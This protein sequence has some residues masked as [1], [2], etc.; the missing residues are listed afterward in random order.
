MEGTW[1]IIGCN[2]KKANFLSFA[3]SATKIELGLCFQSILIQFFFY[4][5]ALGFDNIFG[6]TFLL[7]LMLFDW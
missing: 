7:L 2:L 1:K 5:K 6:T 3:L 4:R